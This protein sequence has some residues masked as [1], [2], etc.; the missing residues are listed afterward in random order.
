MTEKNLIFLISAPRSGSSML[1]QVILNNK[2]ISGTPEPWFMLPLI[3]SYKDNGI[4]QEYNPMYGAINWSNILDQYG[5]RNNYINLLKEFALKIYS[6]LSTEKECSYFIDKTPRYYHII[7]ELK[8]LFPTAKFIILKRN[9]LAIFVSILNY[10]FN[11]NLS[12]FLR[13][14]DRIDDIFKAPRILAQETADNSTFL[15]KYEDFVISPRKHHKEI[16][17]FLGLAF[18]ENEDMVN[19]ELGSAFL[20]TKG[21]DQRGLKHHDQ[22]VTAYLESWRQ[23]IDNNQKSHVALEYME[24]LGQETFYRLGYSF[25]K[26]KQQLEAHP[27]ERVT[28]MPL[29]FSMI[30]DPF[31]SLSFRDRNFIRIKN[32]LKL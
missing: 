19:Y 26:T 6:T 24:R 2:N 14:P 13:A 22:P 30:S 23:F 5:L 12:K 32:K 28:R 21:I 9:P 7:K 10:N 29:S 3:Y 20:N 16:M 18:N 4:Q 11:G 1:Q 8:E 27:V 15:I 17:D 25:D 31:E